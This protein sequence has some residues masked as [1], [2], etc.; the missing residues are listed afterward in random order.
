[1][2]VMYQNVRSCE[3]FR[4]FELET[5]DEIDNN[6]FIQNWSHKDGFDDMVFTINYLFG[7]KAANAK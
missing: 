3:L 4:T 7:T 5:F 2:C 6:T 1:M